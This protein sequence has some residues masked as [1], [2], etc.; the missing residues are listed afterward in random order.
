MHSACDYDCWFILVH[1]SRYILFTEHIPLFIITVI[2][3][4]KWHQIS[5]I[6]F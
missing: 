4:S 2:M 6:V 3:T 5:Y 1:L